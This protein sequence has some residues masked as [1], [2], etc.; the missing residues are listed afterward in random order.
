MS[1]TDSWKVVDE[2]HFDET[3]D[4]DDLFWNGCVKLWE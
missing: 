3:D 2:Y 1:R 4:S